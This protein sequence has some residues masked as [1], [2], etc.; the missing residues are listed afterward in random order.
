MDINQNNRKFSPL[1]EGSSWISNERSFEE[2]KK[3]RRNCNISMAIIA[4][5]MLVIICFLSTND[6]L[7]P[8]DS[9]SDLNVLISGENF[10]KYGFLKLHFLPVQYL[11]S[12]SDTPGYYLH[13][14]P[15]PNLINGLLQRAG[16]KSLSVMR[17]ISGITLIIGIICLYLALA[18]IIGPLAAVC[19]I[20]FFTTTVYFFEYAVSIHTQ[21]YNIFFLGLFLLLFLSGIHSEKKQRNI[22]IICWF[23]LLFSSLTS[24]EFILYPQIFAWLYI[25]AT[26]QL[27][28]RWRLLI[29]L[30]T[31]PL[32]AVGVHFLQ[33]IWAVGFI[34]ATADNMGFSKRDGGL[35]SERWISLLQLPKITLERSMTLFHFSWIAILFFAALILPL[36]KHIP[37][38][39]PYKTRALIWGIFFASTG[40]YLFMPSHSKAHWHTTNQILLLTIVSVGCISAILIS[41]IWKHNSPGWGKFI[42]LTAFLILLASNIAS[43]RER[44]KEGGCDCA[45]NNHTI[46]YA[47]GPHGLPAKTAFFTNEEFSNGPFASYFTHR[48]AWWLS[49]DKLPDA[50]LI[51]KLQTSIGE[52]WRIKYY[53]WG[54]KGNYKKGKIFQYLAANFLGREK[55]VKLSNHKDILT[56]I[57]FDLGPLSIPGEE[58]TGLDPAIKENQ[59]KGLFPKW[60]IPDFE[61]RLAQA[62]KNGRIPVLR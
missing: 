13:Y 17:I 8:N 12:L 19:G 36:K 60:E 28:R 47:I 1:G 40:W 26:G 35:N 6:V 39:V 16:I 23:I 57:L 7:W 51:N 56:L 43:I 38:L 27:R 22:W 29:I 3:L 48:P 14:P 5:I 30:A 46:L 62:Y 54:S 44:F 55:V 53:L 9:Y 31:A 24:F 49:E 41:N 58:K 18:K 20:G 45:R 25:W 61:Q 33:N 21:T 59:L 32:A 42:I 52:D 4:V 37:L 15:L 34:K 2:D 11:G 50:K 10:A